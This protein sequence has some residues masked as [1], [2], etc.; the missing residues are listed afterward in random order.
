VIRINQDSNQNIYVTLTENKV[1][2]SDYYLMECTNQVTNDISYC[3]LFGDSSNFKERYNTFRITLDPDNINKG[4]SK[5]LYL[6]YSGFYT[7]VIF[8]TTLTTEEYN[9]LTDAERATNS[10]LGQLETG[11]LWYIPTAQNNTEYNPTDSTTFVYT[12]Q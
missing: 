11:L 1:G 8:E 3:I 2:T 10:I 4:I 5:H 12:P 7:Y 9:T 6:P